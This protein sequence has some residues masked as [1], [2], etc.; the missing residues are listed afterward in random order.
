MRKK[1]ISLVEF[2]ELR[3]PRTSQ[4]AY[5]LGPAQWPAAT[6]P[7]CG[8]NCLQ[9]EHGAP[10]A[11]TSKKTCFSSFRLAIFLRHHGE[12]GY[13]SGGKT[14]F[15]NKMGSIQSA[16]LAW[17]LRNQERKKKG[18]WKQLQLTTDVLFIRNVAR[19]SFLVSWTSFFPLMGR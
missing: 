18:R 15:L 13:M 14:K 16:D 9:C 3:R 10:R 8:E 5:Q 11:H 19:T 4:N 12:S 7:S 17:L 6:H 1:E 2:S